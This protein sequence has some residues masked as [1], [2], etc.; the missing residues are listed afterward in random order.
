METND[1]IQCDEGTVFA[2]ERKCNDHLRK[3]YRYFD[4]PSYI[5][6]P[7]LILRG[8]YVYLHHILEHLFAT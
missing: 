8:L 2:Q 4:D 1:R 7:M 3:D 6:I 5:E